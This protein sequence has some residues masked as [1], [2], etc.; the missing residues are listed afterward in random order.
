MIPD[1]SAGPCFMSYPSRYRTAFAFSDLSISPLLLPALRS[2]CHASRSW[3]SDDFST[4]RVIILTDNLGAAWTPVALQ[5]RASTLITCI[6]ATHVSAGKHAFSLLTSVGWSGPSDGAS[7]TI[8]LISPYCP[9][10][11]LNRRK[12]PEGFSCRHSNP[13]WYIV[14]GLRTKYTARTQHAA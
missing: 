7:T 13:I 10:L 5:S 1:F 2:A 12:F 11:A 9:A 8:H 6:L 4:F 14:S 3:R